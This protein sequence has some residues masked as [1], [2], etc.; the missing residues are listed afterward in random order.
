MNIVNLH[1]LKEV[2]KGNEKYHYRLIEQYNPMLYK[3]GNF[4]LNSSY[5]KHADI[6][7]A[8]QEVWIKVF[9]YIEILDDL[10]KFPNWLSKIMK[11][12]CINMQKKNTEFVKKNILVDLE[13]RHDLIEKIEDDEIDQINITD[14]QAMMSVLNELPEVYS[15]IL[16]MYYFTGFRIKDIAVTQ[17][18]SESLV[19]WRLTKARDMLKKKTKTKIKNDGR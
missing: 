5:K 18:I 15:N 9:K 16:K 1:I 11:N 14:R 13:N 7:D 3:L 12:Q 17:G 6:D 4:Y 2:K 19:K 8:I 10:S